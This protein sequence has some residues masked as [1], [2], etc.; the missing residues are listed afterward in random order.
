MGFLQGVHVLQK[1][2]FKFFF[3]MELSFF[4]SLSV[5]VFNRLSICMLDLE[6]SE[7]FLATSKHRSDYFSC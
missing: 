3:R 6:E 2:C 1:A 7:K 5:F 4:P